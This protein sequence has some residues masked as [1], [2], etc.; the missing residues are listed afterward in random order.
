MQDPHSVITQAA[1][2]HVIELAEEYGVR[3]TRM[4]EILGKDN[5]YPKSRTLIRRL[6]KFNKQGVRLIRADMNAL[7]TQILGDQPPADITAA[8]VH[9]EAFEAI[10]AMLTN[11][12]A[13]QQ[14]DELR[15]LIAVCEQKIAGIE[16]FATNGGLHIA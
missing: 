2:G 3:I 11:K 13:G 15:E 4:Y 6:G 5:P 8:A 10:D 14:I 7:F 12:P 16:R 9:K 1:A